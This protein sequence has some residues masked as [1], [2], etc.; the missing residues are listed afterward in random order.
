MLKSILVPETWTSAMEAA[1]Q[2]MKA[3]GQENPF[4]VLMLQGCVLW[5]SFL[6]FVIVQC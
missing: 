6:V 3:W 5:G 4:G 2:R 1:L